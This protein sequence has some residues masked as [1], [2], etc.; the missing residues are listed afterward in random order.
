MKESILYYY[1]I[2]VNNIRKFKDDFY[3]DYNGSNYI[4]SKY[5]RNVN[6][7]D[8][9]LK[10]NKYMISL[11]IPVFIVL[12]NKDNDILFKFEDDEYVVMKYPDIDNRVISYEDII[13]F[14]YLVNVDN[15]SSLDRANWAK[16]WEKKID[17]YEEEMKEYKISDILDSFNYYVGLAENSIS[18]L[19][20]NVRLSDIRFISHIRL[21]ISSDLYDF[22]NPLNLIIDLRERDVGEYLK[23]YVMNYSYTKDSLL[24]MLNLDNRDSVILLISRVLIPTY[25]FDR[26]DKYMLKEEVDINNISFKRKNINF[27]IKLIFDKYKSFN[28]PYINWIIKEN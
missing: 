28:L 22:Y 2:E 25:Y 27:L 5:I 4:I 10:L 11:N 13:N 15:F 3:F 20:Y 16:Y 24:S 1:N 23:S 12:T 7:K 18:Y 14:N 17:Y 26:Y 19:N 8:D 9:I 6:E 21:D